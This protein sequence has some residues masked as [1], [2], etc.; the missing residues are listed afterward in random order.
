[1]NDVKIDVFRSGGA[2]GQNVNKVETAI[3]MTHL[4]TGIVVQCQD[5][6]S[7]LK[8]REKALKVL[9]ARLYDLKSG[10]QMQRLQLEEN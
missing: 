4:P 10:E 8:N 9:M 5:E 7:Q 3:R 1:M 2:G 6:R